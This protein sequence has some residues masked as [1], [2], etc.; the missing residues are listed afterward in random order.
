ME[1]QRDQC[2]LCVSQ[3]IEYGFRADGQRLHRCLECESFF[4]LPI[5]NSDVAFGS[6]GLTDEPEGS[7]KSAALDKSYSH[8][9]S[10][11]K[12]YRAR[13]PRTLL[14]AGP[15]GNGFE[16]AIKSCG[17]KVSYAKT[18]EQMEASFDA[19]VLFEILGERTDPFRQLSLMHQLLG[20]DGTLMLTIPVPR[21]LNDYKTKKFLNESSKARAVYFNKHSLSTFLVRCGFRDIVTWEEGDGI[22]LACRKT[23]HPPG[24]R[25][26]RLS[27]VLPV[28]NEAR[29][30]KE[31]IDTV[32]AK[33][34]DG[35]EREVVIVESNST[36]GSREIVKQY[37]THPDVRIILEDKPRGKGYAV[38]N[39]ISYASGEIL[40][41]QDADLEY[42][43]GDYDALIEPILARRRLFVL[44]SRHKGNWK[45]RQFDDRRW[46][47]T[48]FNLG[49]I[50]FTWLINF[51]CGT[52][53]KDPFTMYKVF[54]R[55]CLYGLRLEAN[56][57]DLDWEIVIKF[58]RKGLVPQE[59]PVNYV[60][61]SFAEGKKVRPLLDPLL[62]LWALIRFRYGPLFGQDDQDRRVL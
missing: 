12:Q 59:I 19:C 46:F 39:G 4:T 37:E 42:D 22:L 11:L 53:L 60:S 35:V 13:I 26:R 43:I 62:W 54:H 38:R 15:F 5:P 55:E 3:R 18:G 45:M 8:V 25:V 6:S 50:F 23:E 7:Q 29:T 47:G 14:V 61:R 41:I 10:R 30:C 44:G 32:L 40:L 51:T 27:I 24:E 33:G 36:D 52:Q 17:V 20:P 48:L 9:A 31:L 49:Q 2:P 1:T 34:I 56:R 16:E 58:V 21:N 57:F 28:Y